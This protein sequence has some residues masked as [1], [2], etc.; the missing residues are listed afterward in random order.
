MSMI[1]LITDTWRLTPSTDPEVN[2]QLTERLLV[3]SVFVYFFLLILIKGS[4]K[5]DSHIYR[6]IQRHSIQLSLN[7]HQRYIKG[8][9]IPDRQI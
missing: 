2:P 8:T 1:K 6:F 3:N 4:T 5:T 9:N 7:L